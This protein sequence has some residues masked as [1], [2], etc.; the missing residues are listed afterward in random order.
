M[1]IIKAL[2][3][4]HQ[5]TSFFAV[6]GCTTNGKC[7]NCGITTSVLPLSESKPAKRVVFFC[8]ACQTFTK[9]LPKIFKVPSG[10]SEYP[11]RAPDIARPLAPGELDMWIRS[12]PKRKAAGLDLISN[13]IL[14]A[15][16]GDARMELENL[17]NKALAG[18]GEV[19]HKIA[20]VRLLAKSCECHLLEETRPICVLSA[21]TRL[22]QSI[23]AQ[24]ISKVAEEHSL[25]TPNQEGFRPQ[26]ST[27]RQADRLIGI[28]EQAEEEKTPLLLLYLDFSNF[29]NTVA[30]EAIECIMTT[31]GFHEEDVQVVKA[32]NRGIELQIQTEHFTTPNIP[33]LRGLPQGAASSPQL[34]NLLLSILSRQLN[35]ANRREKEYNNLSFADDL[36]LIAKSVMEM[37]ELVTIVE[38]FCTWSGLEI[39][40]KK[41]ELTSFDYRT[42]QE[43]PGAQNI[44][45]L[46]KKF[47]ILSPIKP[48]KYLGFRISLWKK[49][50]R[51]KKCCPFTWGEKEYILEKTKHLSKT[52]AETGYT[53]AQK[54]YLVKV[55]ILNA[56]RYSAILVGWS[57]K[58]LEEV[59]RLWTAAFKKAIGV[60]KSTGTAIF[61]LPKARGGLELPHP[62]AILGRAAISFLEKEG[63]KEG[64]L[65][66]RLLAKLERWKNQLGCQT[67]GE[68]QREAQKR[69]SDKENVRGVERLALWIAGK[70]QTTISWQV[71]EDNQQPGSILLLHQMEDKIREQEGESE[72][73]VTEGWHRF[74]TTWRALPRAGFVHLN[75]VQP[76]GDRT[77]HLPKI[78]WPFPRQREQA[79]L[80][81]RRYLGREVLWVRTLQQT[82]GN[83]RSRQIEEQNSSRKRAKD[84]SGES[85]VTRQPQHQQ[86]THTEKRTPRALLARILEKSSNA[87]VF[88]RTG[89]FTY[90]VQEGMALLERHRSRNEAFSEPSIASAPFQPPTEDKRP[91]NITLL[92]CIVANIGEGTATAEAWWE[93]LEQAIQEIAGKS[94]G[95]PLAFE[96]FKHLEGLI[97]NE[98]TAIFHNWP[99]LHRYPGWTRRSRLASA[100]TPWKVIWIREKIDLSEMAEEEDP[101]TILIGW[102]QISR[103]VNLPSN[104][105]QVGDIPAGK[106]ICYPTHFW[107]TGDRSLVKSRDNLWIFCKQS[108]SE[109]IIVQLAV[110]TCPEEHQLA[111]LREKISRELADSEEEAEKQEFA[112]T[113]A[114]GIHG[115]I[116]HSRKG[117]GMAVGY[118]LNLGQDKEPSQL[119]KGMQIHGRC[120]MIR[121]YLIALCLA[122]ETLREQREMHE[123]IT[124]INIYFQS[125]RFHRYIIN[126]LRLDTIEYEDELTQD[127]ENQLRAL[128]GTFQRQQVQICLRHVSIQNQL[129]QDAQ[130][131]ARSGSTT[132]GSAWERM[133]I[134]RDMCFAIGG[135]GTSK[136]GIER[137][138]QWDQI[139]RE[140]EL[141]SRKKRG[142]LTLSERFLLEENAGRR[143]LGKAFQKT[144][145]SVLRVSIQAITFGVPTRK[146][147]FLWGKTN[148][149]FCAWC[150]GREET[151][152]HIQLA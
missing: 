35:A 148:S 72:G 138:K 107:R 41:S 103:L 108:V 89:F 126:T 51:A 115:E 19:L 1:R 25:L 54:Y 98:S 73:Q 130:I 47:V 9:I 75:D 125:T 45:F 149:P 18:D 53:C 119:G 42:K 57:W 21:I 24:R 143:W 61:Q 33:L 85:T 150:E 90:Q 111:G 118:T 88:K 124:K 20:R 2:E 129:V 113:M 49:G 94:T 4:E 71:F 84:A 109:R 151:W 37:K 116:T 65:R 50:G 136:P 96:F 117:R 8:T 74:A 132:F 100:T 105:I 92:S 31:L 134:D 114:A 44:T 62:A 68:I 120:S 144:R 38:N 152:G 10:I 43:V 141:A 78:L 22:V 34:S 28:I 91:D 46:G 56:F 11:Q 135:E 7:F 123:G 122:L 79:E 3:D 145:G 29:F 83:K 131:L 30:L 82:S 40:T 66:D 69:I 36:V 101:H 48:F 67:I 110:H 97:E 5:T 64:D 127:L 140:E 87:T 23:I 112:A 32:C 86:P 52:I 76:I 14:K 26:H 102:K 80:I 106:P 146:K 99:T 137:L 147:L 12:A 139:I 15:L 55:S 70:M 6:N 142:T 63:N 93:H 133:K 77:I 58:D 27:A 121:A 16:P 95:Q 13:E 17:I 60:S 81:V 59:D 104:F 39:N 128:L